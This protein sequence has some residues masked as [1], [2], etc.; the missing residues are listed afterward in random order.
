MFSAIFQRQREKRKLMRG[1][2]GQRE[3]GREGDG[4]VTKDWN[5]VMQ[6]RA[7]SLEQ[8]QQC[9]QEHTARRDTF[10]LPDS[11]GPDIRCSCQVT[12]HELT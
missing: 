7:Q 6:N 9:G 5:F 10:V 1:S 3:L 8:V 4:K 11:I 12:R 2:E